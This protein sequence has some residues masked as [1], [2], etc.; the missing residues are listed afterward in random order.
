MQ[1]IVAIVNIILMVLSTIGDT[2]ILLAKFVYLSLLWFLKSILKSLLSIKTAIINV[3][4]T[5]IKIIH[6]IDNGFKLNEFRL[7]LLIKSLKRKF[8]RNKK[9]LT[10]TKQE[11]EIERNQVTIYPVPRNIKVKLKY[12]VFG[13]LKSFAARRF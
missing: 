3:F 9:A 10:K 5:L 7:V 1:F 6:K 4:K 12:F 13:L 2:V 8:S 11:K